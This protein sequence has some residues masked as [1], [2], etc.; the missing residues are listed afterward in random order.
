MKKIYLAAICLLSSS[1]FGQTNLDM[2]SWTTVSV[3]SFPS[4]V[5]FDSLNGWESS[6]DLMR[7]LIISSGQSAVIGLVPRTA[8]QSQHLMKELMLLV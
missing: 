1:L 5:D 3:P 4:A 7:N 2:E 6:D 8:Y